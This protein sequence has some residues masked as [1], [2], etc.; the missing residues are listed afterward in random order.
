MS[1]EKHSFVLWFVENIREATFAA[2]L[3]VKVGRHE[4]S[5]AALLRRALP[6]EPIDLSVVVNLVVLQHRQL[7]LSVLVLDLLG[8]G[9][10]LLLPFLCTTPQS[11]H[12]MKGALLL[13]VV[14]RES[15]TILQLFSGKNHPLLVRGDPLLVLDLCLHILDGVARFHLEGDCLAREGFDKDLHGPC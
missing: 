5:S 15:A 1:Y 12:Q 2:V 13:N 7:H 14:V 11:E 9:V 3:P 10:V 8:G 4:N 6:P